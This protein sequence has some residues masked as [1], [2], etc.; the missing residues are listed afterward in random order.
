M[1][2]NPTYDLIA[3]CAFGLEAV[4]RRELEQ[5]G[6]EST[7]GESGRVH[8][9]GTM[10]TICQANLWLR[11]ADRVLI[12]V[13]EFPA[14]DF[15]AL[16]DT[17]RAIE[18]GKTIP[19]DGQ[20]T[21][22]GRSIKSTLTSVPAN[23]RAV[24]KAMVDALRRD[25]STELLPE[26]GAA[27]KI[28][29]ALLKDIA[30]LTIDTTGRSLHRRGYRIHISKAPLKETLAAAL[31]MLSFWKRDKPLLDPFCGSGTIPIEAAL[32]GRNMAPGRNREFACELWPGT[33]ADIFA[34]GRNAADVAVLEP[35]EERIIGSDIDER[36]LKAAR[37]N[38]RARRRRWRHPLSSQIDGRRDQQKAFWLSDNQSAI[39]S[40]DRA[41]P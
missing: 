25:H 31:V 8:F 12:R 26:T 11:A 33:D 36:I 19:A 38:A 28:D 3:A 9:R 13:A 18:W 40:A 7:I 39:R 1:N 6:I 10:E 15:D 22:T 35:L 37:E 27:Y 2:N 24:K 30:T 41:R 34:A 21:V 23:Q 14:A 16:F 29:I 17:T 5:L 20:F 32:I 4:V